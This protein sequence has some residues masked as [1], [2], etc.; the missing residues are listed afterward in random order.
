MT[1]RCIV[2]L[3]D[4]QRALLKPLLD[5]LQPGETILAQVYPDDMRV[6]V[7][8][9]HLTAAIRRATGAEHLTTP[10]GSAQEAQDEVAGQRATKH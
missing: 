4:E 9:A 2:P 5:S 1:R 3:T 6:Q 10:H 7:V 8:P